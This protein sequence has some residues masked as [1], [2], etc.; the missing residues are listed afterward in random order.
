MLK[1]LRKGNRIIG[2]MLQNSYFVLGDDV[3][4]LFFAKDGTL[5]CTCVDFL[6]K[7]ECVHTK[8]I[9]SHDYEEVEVAAAVLE[10]EPE[11]EY[12]VVV[13]DKVHHLVRVNDEWRCNC[14]DFR[15]Q[16]ICPCMSAVS[17]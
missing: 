3:R 7:W 16:G 11:E 1:E 9:A 13:P 5:M 6:S 10:H 15:N 4:E 14:F 17:S 2:Y 8:T 12:Y